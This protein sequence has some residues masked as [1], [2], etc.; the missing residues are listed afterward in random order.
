MIEREILSN[1]EGGDGNRNGEDG[2][3]VGER[4]T[5]RGIR[6]R[7]REGGRERKRKGLPFASTIPMPTTAAPPVIHMIGAGSKHVVYL[8]LLFPGALKKAASEVEQPI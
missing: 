4:E 3:V 6:E 2:E 5:E 8:L 7:K 1:G